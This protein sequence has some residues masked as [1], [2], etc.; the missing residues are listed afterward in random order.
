MADRETAHPDLELLKAYGRGQ[1]DGDRMTEV[2]AHVATCDSCCQEIQSASEDRFIRRLKAACDPPGP[3]VTSED[4]GRNLGAGEEATSPLG[5]QIPSSFVLPEGS[6]PAPTRSGPSTTER[7]TPS[8]VPA[9]LA[10]HPRYRLVKWLGSGG[11]GA[12][13][14]AE[15]RLMERTVALKVIKRE[16]TDHPGLVERFRREVR[17]AARLH[18]PHI[19]TAF[20]AEQAGPLHFL[21]MEFVEGTDLAKLVE[22]RGPLPAAEACESVRQAALGMQYAHEHGMVH[23]DIKP[24]NLMRTPQGQV[25]ILDFGL[26]LFASEVDPSGPVTGSGPVLGGGAFTGSGAVLGTADYIAPEQADDAHRADIRADIYSLGCTLYFLLAGHPPFP[27]GTLI[28]KLSAHS[29]L[30]PAPLDT[31]RADLPHGLV[32]VLDRMMAKDPAHRYQTPAEVALALAPFTEGAA[33]SPPS[34]GVVVDAG[35]PTWTATTDLLPSSARTPGA[36]LPHRRNRSPRRDDSSPGALYRYGFAILAVVLAL[37]LDLLLWPWAKPTAFPLFTAAVLFASWY[38]GLGPGL[39]ATALATAAGRYFFTEPYYTFTV[40]AG[41]PIRLVM[42]AVM[43][44]ATTYATNVRRR[45]ERAPGESEGRYRTLTEAPAGLDLP[46]G[47]L[48]RLPEPPVGLR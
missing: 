7:L 1:L 22:G 28:E 37:L 6:P 48:L 15:H 30:N 33:A 27:G 44:A 3:T 4:L 9:A 17:A 19:V 10:D 26:A 35:S 8:E 2:E 29:R 12:V 46:T 11:M 45:S 43:V 18:H 14:L 23:R 32:P 42:F 20:D 36:S 16:L 47:R 40:D 21:V 24:Q 5:L 34:G 31:I 41:V 25:K 39:L 38:G 13:Y